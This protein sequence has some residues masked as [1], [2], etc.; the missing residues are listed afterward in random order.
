MARAQGTLGPAQKIRIVKIIS[1]IYLQIEAEGKVT[2]AYIPN[3][4]PGILASFREL[5]QTK[6]DSARLQAQVAQDQ[7][8][9][10]QSVPNTAAGA[11][12]SR[13][14]KAAARAQKNTA[15]AARAAAAD[16][17]AALAKVNSHLKE[18]E[19]R[20]TFI[21]CPT[22]FINSEGTRQWKYEAAATAGLTPK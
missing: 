7:Y 6:V 18:L 5:T 22:D 11:A 21:A 20:T 8:A 3:L 16:A 19:S 10:N 1:E 13:A 15:S 14:Q 2:N 9:A 12:Y 4:P 17:A